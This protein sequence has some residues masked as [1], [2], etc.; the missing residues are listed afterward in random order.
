MI[1]KISKN[2]IFKSTVFGILAKAIQGVIA[3]WIVNIIIKS[4]GEVE[5]GKWMTIYSLVSMAGFLD[6]GLGNH[7]MNKIAVFN[8]KEDNDSIRKLIFNTFSIYS[9]VLIVLY[10]LFII[11]YNNYSIALFFSIKDESFNKLIFVTFSLFLI[12]IYSNIYFS[13]L[14]GLQKSYVA[15]FIQLITSIIVLFYTFFF[16]KDKFSFY[17]ISFLSFGIP[18]II[19]IIFLI[20]YLLSNNIVSKDYV[21]NLNLKNNINDLKGSFVFFYLQLAGIIAFQADTIILAKFCDLKAV[22]QYNIVSRLFSIPIIGFSVYYQTLWPLYTHY[23]AKNNWSK[24]KSTYNRTMLFSFFITLLYSLILILCKD[25]IET[26]WLDNKV[27]INMNLIYVFSIWTIFNTSIANN[28]GVLLNSLNIVKSQIYLS[29]IMIILNVFLSI[30]LSN[31]YGVVGVVWGSLIASAFVSC[32]PLSIYI[33]KIFKK[34]I[35]YE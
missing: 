34:N 3:F 10:F 19:S 22:S 23:F 15:N 12:F 18:S 30:L 27:S 4:K 29:F 11:L 31:N 7:L 2:L 28:I 32:L 6:F 13:I 25:L 21:K 26:I 14:R 8:A 1:F 16:V 35:S 24:I 20:Q 17:K 5:Y 33:Q 9:I